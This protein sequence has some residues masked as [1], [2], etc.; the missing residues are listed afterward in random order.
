MVIHLLEQIQD[1]EKIFI[2]GQFNYQTD[3]IIT[4]VTGEIK[5]GKEQIK[6]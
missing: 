3:F 4:Y 2:D 6:L 5:Q 1:E